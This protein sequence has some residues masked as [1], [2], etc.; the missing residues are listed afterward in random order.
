MEEVRWVGWRVF[1]ELISRRGSVWGYRVLGLSPCCLRGPFLLLRVRHVRYR[2]LRVQD[3]GRRLVVTNVSVHAHH[4]ARRA[5]LSKDFNGDRVVLLRCRP[6]K[7]SRLRARLR[8]LP[9]DIRMFGAG[10]V[11][12][13]RANES[14]PNGATFL[15]FAGRSA[16]LFLSLFLC[17]LTFRRDILNLVDRVN[18]NVFVFE[19]WFFKDLFRRVLI[20]ND[21][22]RACV[23]IVD[24]LVDGELREDNQDCH[25]TAGRDLPHFRLQGVGLRSP[26]FR[27]YVRRLFTDT[28]VPHFDPCVRIVRGRFVVCHCVGGART[29]AVHLCATSHA[30]PKLYGVGFRAVFTVQGKGTRVRFVTSRAR[31]LRRLPVPDTVGKVVHNALTHLVET[32][33]L[34]AIQQVSGQFHPQVEVATIVLHPSLAVHVHVDVSPTVRA[35]GVHVSLDSFRRVDSIRPINDGERCGEAAMGDLGVEHFFRAIRRRCVFH[36]QFSFG[37]SRN[38][39]RVVASVAILPR[40][41]DACPVVRFPSRMFDVRHVVMRRRAIAVTMH[42]GNDPSTT[43][44]GAIFPHIKYRVSRQ[45]FKDQRVINAVRVVCVRQFFP[46]D[47]RS[48]VVGQS[49]LVCPTVYFVQLTTSQVVVATRCPLR[50]ST[51]AILYLFHR[52]SLNFRRPT[53]AFLTPC[54]IH[55][56]DYQFHV[57]PSTTPYPVFAIRRLV[58]L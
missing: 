13:Y 56:G 19:R 39:G 30:V 58:L 46:Q 26:A 33:W 3:K 11:S 47:G 51:R 20:L 14:V 8:E 48:F 29:F 6:F 40:G 34:R 18:A 1:G 10:N 55:V 41:V 35:V 9:H 4:Y 16:N 32:R 15:A 54:T 22:T 21:P 45:V 27:G 52:S 57:R 36:Y 42:L 2:P 53:R 17:G 38:A 25:G 49:R 31:D 44:Y 50:L 12:L 23:P 28:I 43:Y 24:P 37:M 5:P 7:I